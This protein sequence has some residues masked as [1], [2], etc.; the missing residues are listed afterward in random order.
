MEFQSAVVGTRPAMRK[1]GWRGAVAAALAVILITSLAATALAGTSGRYVSVASGTLGN[2][3]WNVEMAQIRGERCYGVEAARLGS[4]STSRVC[5]REGHARSVWRQVVG[6]G[7]DGRGASVELEL[8]SARV[9]S[10]RL[11]LGH[12]GGPDGDSGDPAWRRFSTHALSR[13][14][15]RISHMPRDFRFAVV[16]APSDFCV[17]AME[18]FDGQ[19]KLIEKE[20]VPCEG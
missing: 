13:A 19:G 5:G 3:S 12:P 20:A 16:V 15:A 7:G 8:T 9:R 11:L 17:E 2:T 1:R 10:L 6:N 18:A 4:G 14:E